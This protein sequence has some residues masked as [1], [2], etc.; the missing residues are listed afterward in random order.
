M[1][2]I[3]YSPELQLPCRSGDAGTLPAHAIRMC[4]DGFSLHMDRVA[5][6]NRFAAIVVFGSFV[7]LAIFTLLFSFEF[8]TMPMLECFIGMIA[9]IV[10]FYGLSGQMQ[11]ERI[12]S[13][14]VLLAGRVNAWLAMLGLFM[15]SMRHIA[16]QRI[17]IML[18]MLAVILSRLRARLRLCLGLT[19]PNLT[20]FR[21]VPPEA[22]ARL[23]V[24]RFSSPLAALA[25]CFS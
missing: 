3:S 24:A 16:E 1:S 2:A 21:L 8:K 15:L 11:W 23:S 14:N 20:A 19:D 25:A 6:E 7:A 4:C 13:A 17:R 5:R 22:R 12:R 9:W 18:V 10:I